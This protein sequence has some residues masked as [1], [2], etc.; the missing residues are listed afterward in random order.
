[1]KIADIDTIVCDAGMRNWIFVRVRTDDG[2][3]GWGEASTEWRTHSVIGAVRDFEPLLI[4]EDPNRIEH[5]WQKL[6]RQ[7]FWKGGLVTMS[8][9]SGIDQALHDIKAQ[10]LGAPLYELLGG[11]VRDRVRLY[12][13]LGGGE[14]QAVYGA[15]SPEVFAENARRS[16]EDGFDAVKVL[17]VPMGGALPSQAGLRNCEQTMAAVREAV[18]DDVEIMVD[19]HGRCTPAGAIAFARVIREYRPWFIEEPCQ[20]ELIEELPQIAAA[21]GIPIALGE[22][23]AGRNEFLRV[24]RTGA[25]A[26]LQPDVCHCGGVS[27]LRRIAGLAEAFGVTMAP[28]NPLGPI[29]TAHNLHFAMATSNWLIQEQMRNAAPIWSDILTRP[30]EFANGYA[31]PPP[32]PGLGTA[33]DEVVAA[34]HPGT[35]VELQLSTRLSDGTVCDW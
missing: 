29:A 32:G 3:V 2:V 1:M 21:A 8:A 5:L 30:L 17:A 11:R 24:L 19:M 25:V 4:G 14:P 20:P 22:R 35:Q 6:H 27:E 15:L 9:L 10:V 12:D 31:V 16:V 26:V 28:H 33:V 13:H 7:Q 34:A 23:L 18:G